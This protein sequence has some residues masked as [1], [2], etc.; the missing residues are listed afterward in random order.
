VEEG[1]VKFPMSALK[2]IGH[3]PPCDY[4]KHGL[5]K[6]RLILMIKK[7]IEIRLFEEKVEELYLMKGLITGLAHLY[8]GEEAVAVGVISAGQVR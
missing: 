4:S 3:V 2:E 7:M 6:D 8:F 5:V 1:K